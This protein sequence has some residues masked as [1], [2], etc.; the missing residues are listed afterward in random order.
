MAGRL[1]LSEV[2]SQPLSDLGSSMALGAE[3][4]SLLHLTGA[5]ATFANGGV[6][7]PPVSILEIT[8]SQGKPIYKYDE[9]H[10]HG[11]RAV[12]SDVAFLMDSI[13]SDKAAR[14][15]EFGPGNPLEEAFPAAAKTGTTDNFKDNWT[16]GYTPHLA[17]GVWAGNDNGALMQDVVGITGAG[18]IWHDIL[19]YATQ[20]YHFPADDFARP[21]DV[22][23]GT[24]SAITGLAAQPGEPT[25]TDWFID[26]TMPTI[27]GGNDYWK[28]P[29]PSPHQPQP[30]WGV[31]C[32]PIVIPPWPPRQGT[33]N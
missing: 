23:S 20:R 17:V 27:T 18:P 3:D 9:A 28:S 19:A 24:V 21:A 15:Q 14:Y 33:T 29:K 13:L 30:C 22:H 2:A 5:Y 10:P 8:D 26:G 25:T 4:V 7:V 1:G 16:M 31:S 11:V 6:R 32:D 12:R